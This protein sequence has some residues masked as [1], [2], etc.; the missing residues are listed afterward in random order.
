MRDA[1]FP[2]ASQGMV[3]CV[4]TL[5]R[6]GTYSGEQRW[7]TPRDAY[8]DLGAR[9]TELMRDLRAWM[10]LM[11]WAPLKNQ[12]VATVE[13]HRSGWPHMNLVFWSPEFAAWLAEEKRAKLD[14]HI[15]EDD[16][17]FVS[18]EFANLVV[19]AGWGV[20][21]TAEC[22]K[23][24]DESLGYICKVAG[25]A[26]ESIGEI[27]KLTQLPLSAP[28]RFRRIRS[29]KGFLPKRR[30]SDAVTGT[31][32]RRQAGYWGYD[33]MPLHNIK[34]EEAIHN[35][36]NVCAI[37][38]AIW[39]REREAAVRCKKQVRLYGL[40]AIEPPPV[41]RWIRGVRLAYTAPD[42]GK[43]NESNDLLFEQSE[44]LRQQCS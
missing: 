39:E 38:G 14:D 7:E 10:R 41:T 26:D 32:V 4:L 40:A 22:A 17:R 25:K 6:K 9:T 18:G 28:F 8:R 12:W 15:S 27:A 35:C 11:G 3:F 34:G 33:V 16:T 5:D 37:E 19:N 30:K 24:R 20:L 21:S 13:A 42:R 44:I 29:G 31:L 23:S 36:E 2:L 1:F 43:R